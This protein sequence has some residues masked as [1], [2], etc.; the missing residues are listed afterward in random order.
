MFCAVLFCL[1]PGH[2]SP[3]PALDRYDKND[4][5]WRLR[6]YCS[7]AGHDKAIT[8]KHALG[9]HAERCIA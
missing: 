8:P 7:A 1:Q 2:P 4:P 3:S 6:L 5:Y 9:Q